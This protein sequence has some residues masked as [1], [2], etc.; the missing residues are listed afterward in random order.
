MFIQV[1]EISLKT[2]Y[3]G[4]GNLAGQGFI[5]VC[6]YV[7]GFKGGLMLHCTLSDSIIICFIFIDESKICIW[8]SVC[9]AKD[10]FLSI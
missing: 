2:V 1:I 6:I 9:S 7:T 4:K 5:Y 3:I 10:I 8:H